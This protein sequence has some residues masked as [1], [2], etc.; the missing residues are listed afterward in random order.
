M[1]IIVK[2]T[3]MQK[4]PVLHSRESTIAK[5]VRKIREL[6]K[7]GVQ[8]ATLPETVTPHY[9]YFFFVQPAYAKGEEHQRLQTPDLSDNDVIPV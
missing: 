2:A 3:A 1:N 8:F 5:V 4:S 7:Q 6:G 9:P